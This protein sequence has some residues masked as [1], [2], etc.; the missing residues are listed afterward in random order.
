LG[1]DVTTNLITNGGGIHMLKEQLRK[2]NSGK[3]AISFINVMSFALS[4][5]NPPF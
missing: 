1:K 4:C 3:K 5:L 2:S